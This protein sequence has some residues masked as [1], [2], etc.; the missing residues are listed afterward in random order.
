MNI[1]LYSFDTIEFNKLK[2]IIQ[3]MPFQFDNLYLYT[4]NSDKERI[5][6]RDGFNRIIEDYKS[7]KIDKIVF[8]DGLSLGSSQYIRSQI[9][10]RLLYSN[11]EYHCIDEA[12]VNDADYIRMF[13]HMEEHSKKIADKR[14]RIG[15][16]FK[17]RK[18]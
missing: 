2:N 11:C 13:I 3:K 8:E 16:E 10:K 4:E 12:E 15:Q 7:K 6:K 14:S 9:F 18:N 5:R 1:G 17:N